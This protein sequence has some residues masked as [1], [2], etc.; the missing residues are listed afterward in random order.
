[1][2]CIHGAALVVDAALLAVLDTLS[3]RAGCY[4]IGPVACLRIEVDVGD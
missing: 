3:R 2:V 4:G 1:V